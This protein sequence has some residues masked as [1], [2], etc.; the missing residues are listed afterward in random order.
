MTSI[1]ELLDGSEFVAHL[2][3]IKGSKSYA[4]DITFT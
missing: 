1:E 4:S 2:D 3:L